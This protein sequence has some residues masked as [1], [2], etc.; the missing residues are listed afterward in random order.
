M[1]RS[2]CVNLFFFVQSCLTDDGIL[3][4]VLG[5][6]HLAMFAFSLGRWALSTTDDILTFLSVV[7]VVAVVGD[8]AVIG[9]VREGDRVVAKS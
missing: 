4:K 3:R 5:K 9:N 6:G 7:R 1:W 2:W 8:V